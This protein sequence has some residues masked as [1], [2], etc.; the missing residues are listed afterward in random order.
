MPM[1]LDLDTDRRFGLMYKIN[2]MVEKEKC[3][4]EQYIVYYH[5]YTGTIVSNETFLFESRPISSIFILH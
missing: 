4:S 3:I 1:H 5:A 2:T